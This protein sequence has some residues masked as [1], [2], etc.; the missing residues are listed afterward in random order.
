[1]AGVSILVPVQVS[2]F[3]IDGS[4]VLHEEQKIALPTHQIGDVGRGQQ[5]LH[6]DTWLSGRGFLLILIQLA[7]N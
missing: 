3:R 6:G 1:M 4:T 5:Y 7:E 2:A